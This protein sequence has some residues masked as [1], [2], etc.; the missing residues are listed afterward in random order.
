[1]TE[2]MSTQEI[3]AMLE[4]QA[5]LRSLENDESGVL[6]DTAIYLKNQLAELEEVYNPKA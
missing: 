4:E 6:L 3:L 5:R 1:M 2:I